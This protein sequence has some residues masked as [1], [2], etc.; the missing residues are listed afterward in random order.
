MVECHFLVLVPV[1][2]HDKVRAIRA[3]LRPAAA[4]PLVLLQLA[5]LAIQVAVLALQDAGGALV[6]LKNESNP[7]LLLIDLTLSNRLTFC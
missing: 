2:E 7:S 5:G 1:L 6:R 3:L 4:V